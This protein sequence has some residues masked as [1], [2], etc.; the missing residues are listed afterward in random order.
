MFQQPLELWPP[1]AQVPPSLGTSPLSVRNVWRGVHSKH[2]NQ[3][4]NIQV[5]AP[6]G[7]AIGT[8]WRGRDMA[9]PE[10]RRS[11]GC[12]QR[13]ETGFPGGLCRDPR[14]LEGNL[15]EEPLLPAQ[16]KEEPATF[17]GRPGAAQRT[18]A[19]GQVI[20]IKNVN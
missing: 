11:R 17:G 4:E 7:A 6:Q 8:A 5:T 10:M 19:P 3:R 12:P 14:R 2:R 18:Q 13:E 15:P 20:V 1:S 9:I 16:R